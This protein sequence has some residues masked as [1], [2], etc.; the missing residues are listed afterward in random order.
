MSK[1]SSI[2]DRFNQ[3]VL[4]DIYVN[5]IREKCSSGVD[6]I[7]RDTFEKQLD[8]HLSVIE[9]KIKNGSYMYSNYKQ[10]LISKGPYKYPRVIS[11]PTIRD[12][13]T[14]KIIKDLLSESFSSHLSNELIH[15]T[16]Q[17]IKNVINN[18]RHDTF[19]KF[20]I[21]N[22]Y[23]SINHRLLLRKV[24]TGVTSRSVVSL[25][26]KAIKTPTGVKSDRTSKGVPQGLSISNV[27]ADVYMIEL[28]KKY[29][30]A[31]DFFYFR[32]VDDILILCKNADLERI[33]LEIG[34]DFNH[35]KLALNKEK[36]TFGSIQQPFSFLGYEWNGQVF[37]VRRESRYKL[38]TSLLKLFTEYKY[39]R[40]NIHECI[41]R[42]NLRITG[43]RYKGKKYGW[44]FFF[45]QVDDHQFM[46]RLDSLVQKW[47]RSYGIN[48]TTNVKR[49]IRVYKEITL[50]L[51]NTKYI[52]DFDNQTIEEKK[53][54]LRRY[55]G[56][57]TNKYNDYE[58]EVIY[59]RHISK[60]VRDLERDVQ[61]IS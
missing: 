29:S 21:Q 35:M 7:S 54:I 55:F 13:I 59:H 10:I 51:S 31:S 14:L 12:K 44:V 25:I 30:S 52:P 45:S 48:D 60:V 57:M 11:I 6:R 24:K 5:H 42:L 37:T 39:S 41:W 19:L 47:C 8:E 43:C 33:K 50:N 38:E 58:I 15:V 20:D 16:I 61:G 40:L 9:R 1:S 56:V 4:R 28:D 3:E 34:Q 49:F 53:R 36:T 26:R 46:F 22:F 27:L 17:R 23:P 2:T 18:G 32:Y